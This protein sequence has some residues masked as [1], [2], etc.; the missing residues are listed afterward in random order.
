MD[1]EAVRFMLIRDWVDV[2]NTP[3]E[4][5]QPV[6]LERWHHRARCLASATGRS[7]LEVEQ[8]LQGSARH[9]AVERRRELETELA[10]DLATMRALG[11]TPTPPWH[12]RVRALAAVLGV[13]PEALQTDIEAA[14]GAIRVMVCS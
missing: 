4:E 5:R 2:E 8:E 14:A 9:V 7:Q 13:T 3:S 6:R 12:R 11:Q 10:R 1:A